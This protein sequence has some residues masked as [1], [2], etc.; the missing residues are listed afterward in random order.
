MVI[1][2]E[3]KAVLKLAEQEAERVLV[4]GAM[5]GPERAEARTAWAKLKQKFWKAGDRPPS[6]QF[7]IDE[8]KE[9]NTKIA[10]RM[11]E[12]GIAVHDLNTR[13]TSLE[14]IFV[15]LVSERAGAR[16]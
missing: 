1:D 7:S 11:S 16:P 13:Q 3:A 9:W 12:L 5:T 4:R 6:R 15:S 2:E 8:A 14:E 10:K